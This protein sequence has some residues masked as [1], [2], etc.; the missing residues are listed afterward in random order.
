MINNKCSKFLLII[1]IFGL[2]TCIFD[3]NGIE[4]LSVVAR[5]EHEPH[6]DWQTVNMDSFIS[7][8]LGSSNYGDDTYLKIG[9]A[10]SGQNVTYLYFNLQ[11]YDTSTA[12]RADLYIYVTSITQEAVLN[13]HVANS[14]AWNEDSITWNNAPTFGNS[15]A[16]KTVN[17]AGFVTFDVSSVLIHSNIPEITLIIATESNSRLRIRS[18]ENM[19]TIMEDEYPHLI[20]I[21]DIVPGFDLLIFT[22]L[23]STVIIFISFRLI[24]QRDIKVKG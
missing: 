13:V 18:K 9:D 19:D 6:D 7:E 5:D 12:K 23:I 10:I 11:S 17:S 20:F 8:R 14:D 4:N 1:L 22:L 16:H 3:E 21:R 24:K 2:I 15:I